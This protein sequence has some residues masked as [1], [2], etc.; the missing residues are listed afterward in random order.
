M[1]VLD[2]SKHEQFAKLVA[3]GVS[4]TKAY[5]SA[6]YSANG[7]RVGGARLNAKATVRA[8]IRQIQET[9]CAGTIALEISSRNARVTALQKRWDSLR[10]GLDLIMQQRGADMADVPGGASGLMMRD[11]KGKEADRLVTRIDPG[12]IALVA[13]LR[14]HERQAAEELEQWKAHVEERK[15]IDASPAEITLAMV[16][17]REHLLEMKRKALELQQQEPTA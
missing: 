3:K 11:F 15:V 17:S 16:C 13:E 10:A 7:A 1:S 12:V 2:N 9:L 4:A 5:V 14:S 6:G 8:R